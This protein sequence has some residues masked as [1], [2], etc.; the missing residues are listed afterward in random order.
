MSVPAFERPDFP[1]AD[2][3]NLCSLVLPIFGCMKCLSSELVRACR[4]EDELFGL[5]P[6][7]GWKLR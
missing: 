2:Y 7:A 1:G 5:R 6:C 4:P 3:S